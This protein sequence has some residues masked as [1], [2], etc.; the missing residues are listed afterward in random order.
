MTRILFDGAEFG[1][2]EKFDVLANIKKV[3]YFYSDREA[4]TF[5]CDVSFCVENFPEFIEFLKDN[6]EGFEFKLENKEGWQKID[7]AFESLNLTLH[8]DGKWTSDCGT[9]KY[10]ELLL[11]E[12]KTDF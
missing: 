1:T 5:D 2:S 6:V 8:R 9:E 4:E 7:S 3:K 11:S 12:G 10:D